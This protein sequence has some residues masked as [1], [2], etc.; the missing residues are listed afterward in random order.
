[1]GAEV[2]G[3][4]LASPECFCSSVLSSE[5]DREIR[6]W[7]RLRAVWR[8][9]EKYENATKIYFFTRLMGEQDNSMI[10]L[11]EGSLKILSILPMLISF[12]SN[13]CPL[14]SLSF[15]IIRYIHQNAFQDVIDHKFKTRD[16]LIMSN[17]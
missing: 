15:F 11:L 13:C 17:S 9:I 8:L 7:N 1:M 6:A 2:Q 14:V 12:L 16:N 5:H 4:I 3:E 10:V